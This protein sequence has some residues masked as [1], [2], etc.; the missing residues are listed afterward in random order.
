MGITYDGLFLGFLVA[1][2]YAFSEVLVWVAVGTWNYCRWWGFICG[3]ASG[4]SSAACG[5][6]LHVDMVVGETL[7][8]LLGSNFGPLQ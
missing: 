2:K 8:S 1:A 6:S 5:F 3:L 7:D 4:G